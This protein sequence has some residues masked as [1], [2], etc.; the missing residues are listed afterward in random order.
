M[1]K[2]SCQRKVKI[3]WACLLLAMLCSVSA[4]GQTKTEDVFAP[5]PADLRAS[6]AERLKLLIEYQRT[7]QWGKHYDLL[8]YTSTQ[9]ES[10]EEYVK[11]NQHWYT[12]VVPEVL[13][14]DFILKAL[15]THESSAKVGWWAIEGCAKF[16]G[17]GGGIKELYAEVDAHR[18]R[19]NWFFSPIGAITPI[20][21]NPKP[22]PFR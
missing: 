8:S 1:L 11:R 9:G 3:Q 15:I 10:K 2:R 19:G 22:C 14:L 17:K 4:Q 16:R 5:V 7:Q 12:D 21:G 18:E 13:I 20:D 6:L